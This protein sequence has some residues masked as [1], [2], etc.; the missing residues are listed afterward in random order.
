MDMEDE[1]SRVTFTDETKVARIP[2]SELPAMHQWIIRHSGGLVSNARQASYALGILVL[3]AIA[4]S[5]FLYP[6]PDTK[7]LTPE[8]EAFLEQN[9]SPQSYDATLFSP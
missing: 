5:F 7:R 3:F 6:R 1:Q 9:R 2:R 8:E 4:T